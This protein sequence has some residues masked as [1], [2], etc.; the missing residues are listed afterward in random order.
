MA[1]RN[2]SRRDSI[3]LHARRNPAQPGRM[4]QTS[5]P[6]FASSRCA[7]K[8]S[9]DTAPAASRIS[10]PFRVKLVD[11]AADAA[12]LGSVVD[13]PAPA[14]PKW[15]RSMISTTGRLRQRVLVNYL[16]AKKF[17]LSKKVNR[18]MLSNLPSESR[19]SALLFTGGV[20]HYLPQLTILC[21]RV[22]VGGN[23]ILFS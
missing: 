10:R 2:C 19:I 16:I 6:S 15:R 13:R 3:P 12:G 22:G 20:N 11:E 17:G 9:S 1:R 23:V 18:P 8:R 4:L 5:V 7:K 21:H 14:I